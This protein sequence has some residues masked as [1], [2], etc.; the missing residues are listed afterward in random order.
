MRDR[1]IKVILLVSI[2]CV[3]RHTSGESWCKNDTFG[4]ASFGGDSGWVENFEWFS[5]LPVMWEV[6]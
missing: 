2:H 4:F 1:V 5:S 3:K 6:R